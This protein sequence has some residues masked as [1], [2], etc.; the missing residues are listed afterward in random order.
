M[1][2]QARLMETDLTSP[3]DQLPTMAPGVHPM[4]DVVLDTGIVSVTDFAGSV[5][6]SGW[7]NITL[8][9]ADP[10]WWC[11]RT[12]AVNICIR[13]RLDEVNP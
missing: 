3:D 10:V 12:R 13:T 8:R 4:M 6:P 2:T 7:T 9:N 5:F 11:T 1:R